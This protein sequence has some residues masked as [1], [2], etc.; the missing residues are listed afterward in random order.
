M[1]VFSGLHPNGEEVKAKKRKPLDARIGA[2]DKA[3]VAVGCSCTFAKRVSDRCHPAVTPGR[4]EKA[5]EGTAKDQPPRRTKMKVRNLKSRVLQKNCL[6]L[7]LPV[8][9]AISRSWRHCNIGGSPEAM[10]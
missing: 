10:I 1:F 8:D 2:R 7:H 4:I 6:F 5:G 9:S 3:L